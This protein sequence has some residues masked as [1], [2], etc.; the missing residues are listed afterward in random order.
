MDGGLE[1]PL[2]SRALY[3][4]RGGRDTLY[5][6]HGTPYPWTVG[7]QESGGCIRMFHQD[8]IHLA[9]N[10]E[11]GTRVIILSQSETGKWTAAPDGVSS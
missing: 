1:N 7:G 3:L 2:G 9:A 8:A 10:V 5:R 4:Y 6:I 11:D